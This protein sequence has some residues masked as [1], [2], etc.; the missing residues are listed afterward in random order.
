V[1]AGRLRGARGYAS[2]VIFRDVRQ[3]RARAISGVEKKKTKLPYAAAG[4]SPPQKLRL[5][6]EQS[7]AEDTEPRL[8]FLNSATFILCE[9]LTSKTEIKF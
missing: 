5:K 1:D 9:T 2:R 3:Q 7:S 8:L 4:Q 6:A